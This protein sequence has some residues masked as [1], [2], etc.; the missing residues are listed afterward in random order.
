MTT[1]D[2]GLSDYGLVAIFS[3]IFLIFSKLIE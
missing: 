2:Y 3:F 1:M